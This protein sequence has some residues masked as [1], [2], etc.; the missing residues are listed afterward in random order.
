MVPKTEYQPWYGAECLSHREM[1]EQWIDLRLR[2]ECRLFRGKF[3]VTIYD[4][5]N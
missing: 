3:F 1:N 2:P 5:L 4:A